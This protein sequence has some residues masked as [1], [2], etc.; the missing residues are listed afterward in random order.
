VNSKTAWG[1]YRKH[2]DESAESLPGH[3]YKA[4]ERCRQTGLAAMGTVAY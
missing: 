1:L 3:P 4:M 2:F